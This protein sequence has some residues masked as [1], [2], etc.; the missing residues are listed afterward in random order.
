MSQTDY[1]IAE[2]RKYCSPEV[3]DGEPQGRAADVFSLGC[4]FLEM[5]TVIC[6]MHLDQ[7]VDYRS[8][9]A[10]GDDSFHG[11]LD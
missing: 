9:T 2:P 8:Q 3:Y 7:F 4:I 11:N 6:G 10:D 5:V 1:M